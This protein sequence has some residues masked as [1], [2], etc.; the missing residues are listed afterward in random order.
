MNAGSMTCEYV[1]LK[2]TFNQGGLVLIQGHLCQRLWQSLVFDAGFT[3]WDV[4]GGGRLGLRS[5]NDRL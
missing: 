2:P 1:P 4:A 3:S 5:G